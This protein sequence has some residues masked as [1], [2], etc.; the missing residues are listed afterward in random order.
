MCLKIFQDG[1]VIKTKSYNLFILNTWGNN[2][3][4]TSYK[5]KKN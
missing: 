4:R 1:K 2:L 3:T 5:A